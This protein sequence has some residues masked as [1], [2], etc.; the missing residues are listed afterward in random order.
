[1]FGVV[2]LVVL[3]GAAP[4]A[5]PL[6]LFASAVLREKVKEIYRVLSNRETYETIA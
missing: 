6:V 5:R 2:V 1:M 3:L 4:V